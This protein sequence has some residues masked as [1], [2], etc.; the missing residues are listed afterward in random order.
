MHKRRFPCLL[1]HRPSSIHPLP[2]LPCLNRATHL[3]HLQHQAPFRNLAVRNLPFRELRLLRLLA[4]EHRSQTRGRFTTTTEA[5]SQDSRWDIL[6]IAATHLVFIS[7]PRGF[8]GVWPRPCGGPAI[9]IMH[10]VN[11]G[12]GIPDIGGIGDVPGITGTEDAP[13]PAA[14]VR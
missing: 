6:V 8:T 9:M 3:Y 10:P 14:L 7:T 5:A 11:S 4:E 12:V 13:L 1:L 2:I